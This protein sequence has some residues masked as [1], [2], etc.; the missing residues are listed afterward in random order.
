MHSIPLTPL[1]D[2]LIPMATAPVAAH[3]SI[4]PSDA[5]P[6]NSPSRQLRTRISDQDHRFVELFLLGG[7]KDA[8]AAMREAGFRGWDRKNR[9]ISLQARLQHLIDSEIIRLKRT[10]SMDVDEAQ[11]LVAELGRG[12]DD[13]RVRLGALRTVLEIQGVLSSR[14]AVGDGKE[15][16]K[17][18]EA[19]VNAVKLK[20][21]KGQKVRIRQATQTATQVEIGAEDESADASKQLQNPLDKG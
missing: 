3:I 18:L 10:E 16:R 4:R 14:T 7:C 12:A 15:A 17:G 19:L 21:S 13:E 20:L 8:Q 6:A 11:N 2:S 9:V 1:R 5:E